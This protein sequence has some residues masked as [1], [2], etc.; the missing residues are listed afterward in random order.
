MPDFAARLLVHPANR[1]L[2][3]YLSRSKDGSQWADEPSCSPRL[4]DKPHYSLGTH[5]DCVEFFWD[6]LGSYL[7]EDCR[8]VVWDT[9]V[10]I[11]RTS[12]VIFAFGCGT[13]YCLRL[14]HSDFRAALDKG[15][16]SE[17]IF[18]HNTLLRVSDFGDTWVFGKFK[19]DE[20]DWIKRAYEGASSVESA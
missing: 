1:A 8:W 2:I 11:N 6:K 19:A 13:S 15:Y 12:S 10:L 14:A 7:P 5:P 16:V 17:H 18:G 20:T 4:V 3:E 9:P